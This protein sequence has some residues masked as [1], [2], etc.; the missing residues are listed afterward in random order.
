MHKTSQELFREYALEYFQE[1]MAVL[2]IGPE[3]KDSSKLSD[4]L[5]DEVDYFFGD[6]YN[7]TDVDP[8]KQIRVASP[9]AID[10]IPE[11]F[12]IVF[13][14]NVIEHIERPWIWTKELNR[15]MK[16]GGIVIILCPIDIKQH[17]CVERGE[18]DCFRVLPDGMRILLQ[19]GDFEPLFT[20]A[21][22]FGDSFT[23]CIGIGR[24]R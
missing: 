16:P 15:I 22:K 12:D 3:R 20:A 10:A 21:E 18:V 23:D 1:D 24:K 2:E 13:S 6:L 4:M 14:A 11:S 5:P 9:Y 8:L 17:G 7:F 19:D